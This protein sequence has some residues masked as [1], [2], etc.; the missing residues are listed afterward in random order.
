MGGPGASRWGPAGYAPGVPGV[1]GSAPGSSTSSATSGAKGLVDRISKGDVLVGPDVAKRLV[2]Q[3]NHAKTTAKQLAEMICERSRRL[4]LGLD[5][6]PSEADASLARLLHFTDVLK[7]TESSE[8]A[9]TAVEEIK[10]GVAEEFMSL[11]SSA[12]HKDTVTPMLQRLGFLSGAAAT[13]TDLLGGAATQA[14]EVDLLGGESAS[15]AVSAP[16]DLLG[17]MD[18]A[19]ASAPTPVDT[20]DPLASGTSSASQGLLGISLD[21]PTPSPAAPSAPAPSGPAPA[22]TPA[23]TAAG[24]KTGTLG[25]GAVLPKDSEKEDIFGFVGAEMSKANQK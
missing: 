10:K 23:V 24:A 4:Y 1:P 6:D 25:A 15:G 17:A 22:P 3:C 16:S 19:P 2:S 5:G 18:S 7:Q 20:L 11:R 21:G 12:K 8:F 13:E 14:Q 9:K